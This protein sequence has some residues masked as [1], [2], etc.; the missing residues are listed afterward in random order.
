MEVRSSAKNEKSRDNMDGLKNL[1]K[2]GTRA[3]E[4]LIWNYPR[5]DKITS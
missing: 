3:M 1:D 4:N 5:E 2:S